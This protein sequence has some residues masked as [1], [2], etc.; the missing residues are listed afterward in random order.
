[1]EH[2]LFRAAVGGFHRKDVMEYLEVL[3]REHEAA[4]HTYGRERE[5]AREEARRMEKALTLAQERATDLEEA[6]AKA[7]EAWDAKRAQAETLE[8]RVGALEEELQRTRA[9][10]CECRRTLEAEQTRVS[11]LHQEAESYATVKE[12]LSNIEL[13]AHQRAAEVERAA[14]LEAENIQRKAK[15]N[16]L[17]LQMQYELAMS[18]L[19]AGRRQVTEQLCDMQMA[20][21]TL[22]PVLEQSGKVLVTLCEERCKGAK[23]GKEQGGEKTSMTNKTGVGAV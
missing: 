3:A 2:V 17:S 10:L 22:A 8:G 16:L 5:E 6:R 12:R 7:M 23:P 4:L 14:E 13:S 11:A 20:L 9:T 1:M 21:D 19:D 15:E 18:S